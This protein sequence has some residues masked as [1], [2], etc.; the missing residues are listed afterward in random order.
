VI[1]SLERF[2]YKK[3][4]EGEEVF[5]D[6]THLGEEFL[7]S[8]LP[9]ELKLA[10]IYEGVDP[11]SEPIPIKPSAHYTIGGIDVDREGKTSLPSLFAIGECA[12]AKF[13][14]ANRLGGNSLLEVIFFGLKVGEIAGEEDKR[15]EKR[16]FEQTRKDTQFI[17][18]LFNFPNRIDFWERSEFLSKVLYHNCGIVRDEERLKGSLSLIRQHQRELAFMGVKDKSTTYNTE[19]IKF[20]EYGNMLELSEA[21]VVSALSRKESRGSHFRSDF[22]KQQEEFKAHSVIYKK[23]DVLHLDYRKITK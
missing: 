10:Q 13:H 1:A 7:L 9:Q 18:A 11:L 12:N 14:G 4:E 16:E 21:L 17:Q 19:L 6:I 22:P 15:V 3:L 23:E 8:N 20:L 2:I 5:L